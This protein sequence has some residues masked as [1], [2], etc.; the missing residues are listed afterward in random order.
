MGFF[1]A[2][3]LGQATGTLQGS[4]KFNKK[5]LKLGLGN[6]DTGVAKA[7]PYLDR[8][9][10][11][12][13]NIQDQQQLGYSMYQDSLGLNGPEG[14]TAALDAYQRSPGF[15]LAM[16]M[17]NQNVMRN[18]AAMGGIRSGNAMMDLSERARELQNLDYGAWQTR[19][20]GFDPMRGATGKA[21]ALAD[22][23]NLF[24]DQGKN[25]ATL[26]MQGSQNNAQ[27]AGNLAQMQQAQ[28]VADQ[29]ASMMPLTLGLAGLNAVSGF[30]GA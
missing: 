17:A 23:S 5:Q 4:Q 7:S 16:D 8:A 29:Q 3:D 27:I 28:A 14:N 13:G 2:P 9:V 10:D 6:I 20:A 12:F 24:E 1:D 18:A 19:L 11:N 26:R 21:G 15:G 30:Y 22:L 25:K